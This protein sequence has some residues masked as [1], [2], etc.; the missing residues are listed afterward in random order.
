MYSDVIADSY[1]DSHPIAIAI[2]QPQSNTKHT[3]LFPQETQDSTYTKLRSIS[4]PAKRTNPAPK[5]SIGAHKRLLQ[6]A[7]R[8]A[9]VAETAAHARGAFARARG[10]VLGSS[11]HGCGLGG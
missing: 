5:P 10:D 8:H 7:L 1:I 4:P 2:L 3:P 6:R 9:Q 11:A